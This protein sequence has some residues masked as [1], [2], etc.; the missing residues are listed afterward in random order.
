VDIVITGPGGSSNVVAGDKFTY[1]PVVSAV[2]P[3]SGSHLG[4]TAITIKGAGFT[5]ATAVSFGGTPVTSTITVNATGTQITV[6]APVHAAGAVDV[7][8]TVGGTT[9]NTGST[10]QFTYF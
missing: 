9:T 6:T 2:S 10:D 3:A 7:Q 5:G 1:G 8:V 4:G